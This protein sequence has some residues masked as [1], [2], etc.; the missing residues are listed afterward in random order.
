MSICGPQTQI[1][2][3]ISDI[4][5]AAFRDFRALARPLHNQLPPVTN[6][7]PPHEAALTLVPTAFPNAHTPTHTMDASAPPRFETDAAQLADYLAARRDATLVGAAEF[8]AQIADSLR[9]FERTLRRMKNDVPSIAVPA[10]R[11]RMPGAP[12]STPIG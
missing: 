2:R 10:T 8:R 9:D 3:D 11:L 6:R 12:H 1:R 7:S 5:E 4:F